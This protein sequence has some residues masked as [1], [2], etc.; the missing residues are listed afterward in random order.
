MVIGRIK[1]K[2]SKNKT[3]QNCKSLLELTRVFKDDLTC[4]K[5]LEEML[6]NGN[7][8]CP[9]CATDEKIYRYK[10]GKMFKCGT[11]RKQFTVTVG[12][13]F[14]D[15]HVSLLKWFMAIWCVTNKA[16]GI[17]ST[18]LADEIGVQQRT[19]WF[20]LQ[21][22][23][24]ALQKKSLNVKLSGTVE[25]DETFI[26]PKPTSMHAADKKKLTVGKRIDTN[27]THTVVLG[28][29][30]RGGNVVTKVIKDTTAMS[31]I[32]VVRKTVERGSDLMTD[33]FH[34]YKNM[35]HT[36]N[37]QFVDH[38]VGEYVRGEAHI[39]SMES[40]WNLFKRGRFGV[41]HSMSKKHLQFYLSEFAWRYNSKELS[42]QEKFNLMLNGSEG[43]ITYKELVLNK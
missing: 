38:S 41:F 37:H 24:Y 25:A 3:L 11:C 40:Y 5:H 19:A 20:M 13:I 33:G 18:Q 43:R 29:I 16:K 2:T 31:I 6:W 9:H 32:P 34:V 4:R 1:M 22:I 30:E 17:A 26:Y 7:P 23:R 35:K 42:K 8:V 36:F 14:E 12:T 28:M 21:R 10:N 15:S 39:N 27:K